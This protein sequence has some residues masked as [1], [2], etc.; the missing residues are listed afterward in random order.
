MVEQAYTLDV[1]FRSLGDPTRRDIIKRLS[2]HSMSVGAIAAYYDVSLAAIAK[3]LDVL[4][5]AG[6]VRKTRRGKEQIVT[7]QPQA[8]EEAS[9]YLQEYRR[10]WEKRLD[11]LD[12]YVT[13]NKE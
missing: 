5:R 4:Q 2:G 10:L 11:A 12:A 6:L 13:K 7:I 9:D 3:H 8:L 1:V